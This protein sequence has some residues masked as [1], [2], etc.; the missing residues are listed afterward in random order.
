MSTRAL[1]PFQDG[2]FENDPDGLHLLGTHCR[3]CG[4]TFYPSTLL[5]F[6]CLA[7]G[8]EHISL[9]REGTLE[10]Y[11]TVRM[12][13][14]RIAAPYTVG[15]VKVAQNVRI[16]APIESEGRTLKVGMAMCL[17]VYLL[18]APPDQSLAYCFRPV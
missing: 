4:Q 6:S 8:L 7:T 10:S 11:T 17:A 3:C 2:L 13:A 16:F 5:C 18:G 9:S 12:P 15:Y 14:G 1:R